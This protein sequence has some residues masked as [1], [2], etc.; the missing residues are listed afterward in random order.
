MWSERERE[1]EGSVKKGAGIF[2]RPRC[3]DG[4]EADFFFF[5]SLA[6]FF[7]EEMKKIQRKPG[8]QA[9]REE[10]QEKESEWGLLICSACT[11]HPYSS[12]PLFHRNVLEG[13]YG[14]SERT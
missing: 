5:F 13:N 7:W 12:H 9:K 4:G 1:G 3:C 6:I 11:R 10:V 14:K 8:G 2:R